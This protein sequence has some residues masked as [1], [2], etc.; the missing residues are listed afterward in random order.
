MSDPKT[1][2]LVALFIGLVALAAVIGTILLLATG[3]AA[4]AALSGLAGTALGYLAGV[5]TPS[6]GSTPQAVT[7]V[8][9]PGE[10]VPVEDAGS[11]S[12]AELC[13]LALFLLVVLLLFGVLPR[14]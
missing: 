10:P 3:R 11:I 13:L 8:N 6:T 7:V 1:V 5:M 9:R 4:D 2:R 14:A 12:V